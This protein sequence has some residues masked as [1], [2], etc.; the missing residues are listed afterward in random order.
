MAYNF[1]QCNREQK[2]LLPPDIREWI[3]G[4]DL[5]W[6]VLDAV[7]QM[8]LRAFYSGYRQDGRGGSAYPPDVM[9]SLLLYSYCMGERSSRRIERLCERDVAYRVIT[10]NSFPDHTTI[11]RFRQGHNEAL[12]GLFVEVLRLCAE[13]GLLKVGVVALDGTK[14]KANAALDANRTHEG[15][16]EEVKRMLAEAEAVDKQEDALYGEDKRGDE[17]PE[18]LRDRKGRLA[19]LKEC[20]E[21]LEQEASARAAEQAVKIAERQAEEEATGKKKRGRKPKDP[22]ATVGDAKAN[23]TD[24]DSRIM[25]TRK[26]YEQAYNAQAGTTEDQII[27]VAEVTTDENDAKQYHPMM[28]KAAANLQAVGVKEKIGAGLADAGYW[29]KATVVACDPDGPESFIATTKDWKQRK[30]MRDRAAPRGRIPKD[31]DVRA[32]MERRLLTKRGRELYKKRSQTIEPVFGQVK[33]GRGADRFMRRGLSAVDSEWKV[34][35]ATHNLLKLFRSG[36]AK[37]N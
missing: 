12:A 33:E 28:R 3:P 27:V 37:W 9:V 10:A 32:L 22:D 11:S 34:I 2:Y 19:R 14:M 1:R 20:K 31:L 4:S 29:S 7:K 23:V 15:L 25:K 6:F 17:L 24:P 8:D 21:R 5:A 35:C 13:A 30:A 18:G 16:A 36:K 26:G